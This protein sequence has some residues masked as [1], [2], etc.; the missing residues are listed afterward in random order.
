[1]KPSKSQPPFPTA[2]SRGGRNYARK[3]APEPVGG[4]CGV[5]TPPRSAPPPSPQQPQQGD[6]HSRSKEKSR[7]HRRRG[8]KGSRPYRPTHDM[9]PPCEKYLQTDPFSMYKHNKKAFGTITT[10]TANPEQTSSQ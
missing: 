7:G 6:G 8:G 9:T 10:A 5:D 1:M 4:I 2:N 3:G